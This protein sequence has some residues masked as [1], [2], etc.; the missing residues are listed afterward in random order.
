MTWSEQAACL[1]TPE[2]IWY[3]GKGNSARSAYSNAQWYCDRCPVR[4]E[5]LTEALAVE[6][7][8]ARYGMRAGLT[9]GER[10]AIHNGEQPFPDFPTPPTVYRPEGAAVTVTDISPTQQQPNAAVPTTAEEL[11]A[12]GSAQTSSRI[13]GMAGKAHRVLVDLRQEA[14]RQIRVAESEARIARLKAQLANAEQDLAAAKGTKPK[15][16]KGSGEDYA[17]IRAWAREKGMV[18]ADVGRPARAVIDA[19]HADHQAA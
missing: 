17:A 15:A 5:C 16:T 7:P 19:Y 13:Q 2:A 4:R 3:P 1:G 11:I 9:P 8:S 10:D 14:E 18:V 12:W 6:L